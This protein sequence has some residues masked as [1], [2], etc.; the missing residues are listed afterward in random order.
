M[1]SVT[2]TERNITRILDQDSHRRKFEGSIH[3]LTIEF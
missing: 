2:L 3:S 1:I